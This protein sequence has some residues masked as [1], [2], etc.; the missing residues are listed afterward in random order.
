MIEKYVSP[1]IA[2]QFPVFYKEDGPNFISFVKAYYEWMEQSGQTLYYSRRHLSNIDI[3]TTES[4][5]LK[6][7][8]DNYLSSVPENI[9][10][11]KKLL[12]KH[13]LDL[14]RSKGTPRAYELLFRLLFNESIELYIPGDYLFKPSDGK[15]TVPK[16]IET[17][18][19]PYLYDLIGKG[20]FNSARTATA[21]VDNYTQK[22]VNGKLINVLY[23]SS[24]SGEFK[25]GERIY[26]DVLVDSSGN[27][28]ITDANSPI[29]T[30]S[31]TAVAVESGGQGFSVGN[32][33]DVSGSG[34]EGKAR[35][36]AVRNENGKVQFNLINGGSGFSL[37]AVVTVATTLDLIV[38]NTVGI[39]SNGETV[40]DSITNA[41]GTV[42]FA[43]STF[44]QLIN[45][46]TG[47]NFVSGHTVNS[48]GG[49]SATLTNYVGGG[50]AGATFKVGGI[51]NKQIYY[52]NTDYISGKVNALLDTTDVINI[53]STANTFTVGN[54]VTST[55]NVLF[56]EGT[57]STGNVA[58]V[59]EKLAN[60]TLGVSNLYVYTSDGAQVWVT[61]S[62]SDLSNANVKSGAVLVGNTSSAV[63][64]LVDS[65]GKFTIAS[66]AVVVSSNSIS[67][68]VAGMN[69]NMVPTHVVTDT[70]TSRTAEI[71][72]VTRTTDWAF[73]GNLPNKT[74]LDTQ[75]ASALVF[76]TIE[77]G[78]ISYLSG[79]SP[80][81]GYTSNPYVDVIEPDIA[82]VGQDD[83][84]GGIVGHDA[85]I[86]TTVTNANGIVT[87]VEVVDS[88]FGYVPGETV[89]MSSPGGTITATGASIVEL[90][91][92][93]T[94]RWLDDSGFLDDI[95]KIQD[96]NYYQEY[97]YE[98]V[99]SRMMNTYEKFV[100]DL[101]HPSGLAMF[102]RFQLRND[103]VSEYSTPVQFSLTQT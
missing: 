69:G 18:D 22:N 91:A 95:V 6:Y 34:V 64:T 83:G 41:N 14:Y 84:A 45:F 86:T 3:D 23:L 72:S 87:A 50:G 66:N 42:T 16:Y 78:T 49:A 8:K 73:S 24:V 62:E 12:V 67:I 80:G 26:S 97:S 75:M 47:L 77:A 20:I 9:L 57:Y 85:V 76:K 2:Q 19:C 36:A 31:L 101:I 43:N 61:G 102:G 53:T 92:T 51:V 98:I 46:S 89:S 65:S 100:R 33:L 93:G 68:T 90:G 44:V 5:F 30:G 28:L 29:I 54:T 39:F 96:S 38:A 55:A 1:F 32:I 88:G 81:T 52:I 48:S 99:A 21:V 13:V 103:L 60:S 74:N 82:A 15:W 40:T 56:L 63:Y 70:S 59:G 27:Q 11:D 17:T 37:N 35:V 94:G 7:F 4:A 58:Q 71:T 10:T 79:I 25:R